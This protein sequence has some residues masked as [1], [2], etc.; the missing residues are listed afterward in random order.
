VISYV[1]NAAAT[2]GSIDILNASS[3]VVRTLTLS[4]AALSKGVHVAPWDG[5]DA[6]NAPAPGGLYRARV[7]VAGAAVP[8]GGQVLWGPIDIDPAA[9]T[10]P[11][12][13]GLCVNN[14]PGSPYLGRIYP[15]SYSNDTV[16]SFK[17]DG[18]LNFGIS[19]KDFND[20]NDPLQP[21]G[22]GTRGPYVGPD[23]RLYVGVQ[24][25]ASVGLGVVAGY[26]GMNQLGTDVSRV[27]DSA[28]QQRA[29]VVTGVA[30]N[31]RFYYSQSPSR[32]TAASAGGSVH[33]RTEDGTDTAILDATT[34]ATPF[35]GN[36]DGIVVLDSN[37]DPVGHANNTTVY[38][39]FVLVGTAGE[40]NVVKYDNGSANPATTP[41]VRDAAFN[42]SAALPATSGPNG[43]GLAMDKDGNLWACVAGPLAS[44][45]YIKLS[46]S[47][48]AQMDKVNVP[49]GQGQPQFVGTD[50]AGNVIGL[51]TPEGTTSVRARYMTMYAPQGGAVSNSATSQAFTVTAVVLPPIHITAGPTVFPN[52][53]GATITWT[54]DIASTSEVS[55]GPTASDLSNAATGAASTTSHSVAISGLTKVTPYF[56]QVRSSASGYA[57]AQ[58]SVLSFTTKDVLAIT[59]VQ[60][61]ASQTNATVTWTTDKPTSSTVLYGVTPDAPSQMAVGPVNALQHS[62]PIEGLTAGTAY[63][64]VVVSGSDAAE[65]TTSTEYAFSTLN[66]SG[67]K[68][69]SMRAFGDFKFGLMDEIFLNPTGLTLTKSAPPSGVD[70]AGVTDLPVHRHGNATVAYGGYLYVIGG[71]AGS[72][73]NTVYMAPINADATVGD[74]TL[75]SALPDALVYLQRSGFGYNGYVYVVGGETSPP[76]GAV[77]PQLTTLYAKQNPLDGTLGPWAVAGTFPDPSGDGSGGRG[78]G[79]V[80]AYNGRVYFVGGEDT[81]RTAVRETMFADIHPN[82]TLGAW[83]VATELLPNAVKA[84]G[85]AAHAGKLD[86]WGGTSDGSTALM[87]YE[88]APILTTGQLGPWATNGGGLLPLR[89]AFAGTITHGHA[90]MIGGSDGVALSS[91]ISYTPVAADGTLGDFI[92]AAATYTLPGATPVP[93][94][95]LDGAVWQDRFYIAGGRTTDG[96]ADIDSNAVGLA[97]AITFA[98]SNSYSLKGRY[99]SPII[100]L[101]QS[102]ALKTLAVT[103]SG[104]GVSLSTRFAGADGVFSPWASAAGLSVTFA[105]G[106]SARYVQYALSLTSTGSAAPTVSDV[107]LTYGT[108]FVPF[109]SADALNALK[110]AAGLTLSQPADIQRL[111][112]GV[113]DNQ[114]TLSDAVKVLKSVQ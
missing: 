101:G 71:R 84:G 1:L 99:E 31:R 6:S 17:A 27:F 73:S 58:S 106:S 60:A 4:G 3:Q 42:A 77:M 36:P 79:S 23:D 103:A 63:Y 91:A 82:G 64:Y 61:V 65:T 100:D 55:Y 44:R 59:N 95:D 14:N 16:F 19:Y 107:S 28:N 43:R 89:F 86:S 24:T 114:I 68:V 30:A 40:S 21:L 78:W 5:N 49:S 35:A 75:T 38:V 11:S 66:A 83:T 111:D 81:N 34:D 93:L 9:S 25:D 112:V 54:T 32:A 88:A 45:G 67:L 109:T 70:D 53:T 41:Y 7:N 37:T 94:R 96:S 10:P 104:S 62:V 80:A 50:L 15:T 97:A 85:L 29:L 51:Q 90:L 33:V 113:V 110:I 48:G 12:E 92:D 26:L 72:P 47:T 52:A 22:A 102:E 87:D 105:A 108:P 8:A 39:R 76:S 56:Y 20:N 2:S 98:S 13:Y 18:T 69:R 74:W 57:F 46:K